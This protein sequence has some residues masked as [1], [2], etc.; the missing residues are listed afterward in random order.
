MS[1]DVSSAVAALRAFLAED[2]STFRRLHADLHAGARG[3]YALV[4][5]AAFTS[6]V[7]RRFGEQPSAA[8]VIEF[9]AEARAKYPT[10][11]EAVSAEDAETVIRAATGED[12]LIGAL[13]GRASGAAQTAMLFALTHEGDASADAIEALLESSATQASVARLHSALLC[14]AGFGPRTVE[15]GHESLDVADT[16]VLALRWLEDNPPDSVRIPALEVNPGRA[17]A[18]RD[19]GTLRKPPR[20]SA[21]TI[22]KLPTFP[23]CRRALPEYQASMTWPFTLVSGSEQR[24]DS[25]T[26]PSRIT[27]GTPSAI[28]R[29]RASGRPGPAR[30]ARR[31]PRPGTCRR[32]RGTRRGP[33]RGPRHGSGR[34]ISAAR[35]SPGHG[36]WASCSRLGWRVGAARRPTDPA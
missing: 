2:F 24:S 8:D 29:S 7:I 1:T 25:K 13:D 31:R 11:G 33:G 9:V 19:D 10:T 22:K 36:R 35:V 14:A 32:S 4:V 3:A 12:G 21:L 27:Y 34:G 15:V 26:L 28:A 30:T 16:D 6:A 20:S 23:P 17:V 18:Y 5:T